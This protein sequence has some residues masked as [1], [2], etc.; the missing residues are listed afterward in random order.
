MSQKN[1]YPRTC[2]VLAGMLCVSFTDSNAIP[3]RTLKLNQDALVKGTTTL[4]QHV[5]NV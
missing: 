3:F 2:S 4:E 1:T 5:M